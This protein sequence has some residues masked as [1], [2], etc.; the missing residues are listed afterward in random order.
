MALE[1]EVKL[2]F[3]NAEPLKDPLS[4]LL[5]SFTPNDEILR[6]VV[7]SFHVILKQ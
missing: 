2:I 4:A 6:E 1:R 5:L 7:G 3:V